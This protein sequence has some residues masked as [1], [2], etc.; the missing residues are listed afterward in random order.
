MIVSAFTTALLLGQSAFSLG[1]DRIPS[2]QAD[3]AYE[4]LARGQSDLA[5]QKLE[6]RGAQTSDDPATL[7]NLGAAYARA[8]QNAKAVIAY[9]AA[10][11]SP[12]R[13]DVQLSGGEWVD[14]RQ[15]ARESLEGILSNS[16]VTYR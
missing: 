9:R 6:A 11:N 4:E 3:V 16:H 1:M 13:Y 14:S 15:A 7:I 2:D 8:G 12:V 5:L 10:V